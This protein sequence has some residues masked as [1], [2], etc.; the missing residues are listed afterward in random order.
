MNSYE[1]HP[2][3]EKIRE[4]LVDVEKTQTAAISEAAK[5]S[6]DC[7]SNEGLIHVFGTGHS[8]ILAEEVFFRAGGLVQINA[9]LD[10][11]LMLHVSATGSTDL[12]RMEGYAPFVLAR[13]K[14]LPKDVLVVVSN[15][16][17]NAASIDAAIYAHQLGLKVICITSAEAY[18]KVP[19]RH[20]SGKRL[21]DYA[22][23]VLDTRVPHGDAILSLEGLPNAFGPASTIIGATVIQTFL[24][25]TTKEL[26]RR[27]QKPLVL[28]SANTEKEQDL[29]SMYQK[30][31][32]RIRH[33]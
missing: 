19:S 5:V 22:D 7:I 8:H 33:L 4:I 25:E 3:F 2:F 31:A 12:E 26:L 6:A 11:G 13:Y 27:G 32:P 21:A 17:R 23:V 15:S 9:I 29:Q 14:F 28:V 20:S 16:G 1:I 24:Y 30:Y 10:P 18:K